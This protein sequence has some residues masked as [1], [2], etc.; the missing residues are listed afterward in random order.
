MSETLIRDFGTQLKDVIHQLAD[1]LGVAAQFILTAL[2][3]QEILNGISHILIAIFVAVF[4]FI[5][6][7]GYIKHVHLPTYNYERGEAK[8]KY[9]YVDNEDA[10]GASCAFTCV[11]CLVALIL[12]PI[13]ITWG[14][15]E[16]INPQY[17]ALKEIMAMI[18]GPVK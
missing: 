16:I 13:F 17:Y 1:G 15:K 18:R 11:I 8:P 3:K 12:V 9:W 4:A 6:L 14:I 2:I 5:I 7:K 10:A